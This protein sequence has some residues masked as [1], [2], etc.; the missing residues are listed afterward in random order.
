M[1][2][3]RPI[4]VIHTRA[5]AWLP[6]EWPLWG[7]D[8]ASWVAFF[9]SSGCIPGRISDAP[10]LEAACAEAGLASPECID[11]CVAWGR[12]PDKVWIA[13]QAMIDVSANRPIVVAIHDNDGTDETMLQPEVHLELEGRN[14]RGV[15]VY[16]IGE[17]DSAAEHRALI[18]EFTAAARGGLPGY[19]AALERLKRFLISDPNGP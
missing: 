8:E 7:L 3:P 10:A 2:P 17:G 12:E 13:M 9:H 11:V 5:N 14:R 1:N 16:S 15:F 6:D 19:E 18:A 4:I